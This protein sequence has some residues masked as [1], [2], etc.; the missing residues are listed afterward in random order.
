VD[1]RRGRPG[2]IGPLILITIGALLLLN[3]AGTLPWRIWGILWR[4]WPVI[5][6]LIG[7][8]ILVKGSRSLVVYVIGLLIA[9][10]VLG[11]VIG[12]TVYQGRQDASAW[13]AVSTDTF[14]EG[15]Q[16][17]DRGDIRLRFGAGT[18]AVGALSDSPNLV[19]GKVEYGKYSTKA[20]ASFRVKNGRASFSLEAQSP[21]LPGSIPDLNIGDRWDLGF[22]R[23]IPLDVSVDAGVGKVEVDL[24]DLKV[25]GFSLKTG[26]GE[27]TVTLPAASGKT[28]ASVEMGIGN[29]TVRVPHGVAAE[30]DVSRALCTVRIDERFVRDGDVY[31]SPDYR[32][33]KNKV[34]LQISCAIGNITVR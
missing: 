29:I 3:Q 31:V 17:A 1:E 27:A 25:S 24:S 7:L 11:G 28:S 26:V 5:L 12:Y 13:Q 2:L 19:E 22:T 20:L 32:T 33:A 6:I 16:D 23:R 14:R 8:D 10:V 9:V 30:I 18:L 4:F 15:R 21:S 34:E